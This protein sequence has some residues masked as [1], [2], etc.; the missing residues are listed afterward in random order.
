M[1]S[2]GPVITQ[3][4]EQSAQNDSF[5]HWRQQ[6]ANAFGGGLSALGLNTESFISQSESSSAERCSLTNSPEIPGGIQDGR[7]ELHLEKPK[8]NILDADTHDKVAT[9]LQT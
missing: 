5:S 8:L 7:I 3:I 4:D 2:A 1:G 6:T 9:T